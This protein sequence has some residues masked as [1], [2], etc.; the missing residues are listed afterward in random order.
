[1][2][3]ITSLKNKTKAQ[4]DKLMPEQ[5]EALLNYMESF[6]ALTENEAF[7]EMV[8]LK[9]SPQDILSNNKKLDGIDADI[10]S[11]I[12]GD[13][14]TNYQKL[15]PVCWI[16]YED[17]P[18]SL[19]NAFC[20]DKT[21]LA[22]I[23]MRVIRRIDSPKPLDV[24][25]L[26]FLLNSKEERYCFGGLKELR[27]TEEEANFFK[28]KTVAISQYVCY[29]LSSSKTV[30]KASIPEVSKE[31]R[32]Q[33]ISEKVDSIHELSEKADSEPVAIQQ[34]SAA[35]VIANADIIRDFLSAYDALEEKSKEL[36]AIGI[37]PEEVIKSAVNI[38][39]LLSAA[40]NL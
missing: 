25:R 38:K 16:S 34:L 17:Y 5:K 3:I 10:L 19:K 4:L 8:K 2:K 22:L 33:A 14:C 7:Q 15:H 18:T 29:M 26:K 11:R 39:L 32:N 28:N 23:K 24:A 37:N 20:G 21:L 35:N 13:L 30:L 27:F 6:M 9:I 12:C 31:I 1:M 40:A 36:S